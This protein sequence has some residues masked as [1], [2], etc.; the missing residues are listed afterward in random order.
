MVLVHIWVTCENLLSV[1]ALPIHSPGSRGAFFSYLYG[2]FLNPSQPAQPIA[3]N[4]SR[5]RAHSPQLG[6]F[7]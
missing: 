4:E 1:F 7:V 5:G 3:E 6:L 2:G